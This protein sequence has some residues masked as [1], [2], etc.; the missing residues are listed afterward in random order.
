M[1]VQFNRQFPGVP[2]VDPRMKKTTVCNWLPMQCSHPEMCSMQTAIWGGIPLCLQTD[3]HSAHK[4][5]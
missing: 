4:M 5:S 3:S 1:S 2:H